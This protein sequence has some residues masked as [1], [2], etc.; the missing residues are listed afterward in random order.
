[1]QGTFNVCLG[2]PIGCM[3]FVLPKKFITIFGRPK[4]ANGG[5]VNIVGTRENW[6]MSPLNPS[7]PKLKRKKCKVR[8]V[9]AWA[10][11]L[12]AWNFS[13]QKSLSLFLAWP[14]P[15]TSPTFFLIDWPRQK[16]IETMKVHKHWKFYGQ[17][18]C[19]P[20]WP[21]DICEKG[22]TLS[23]TYGIKAR[24]DWEHPRG[25]HWEPVGT[26]GKF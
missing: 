5:M 18:K 23:K 25:T 22:R 4:W 13:S 24:C 11:P 9:C 8:L 6:K 19:L 16:K 20:L 21:T 10:F 15:L 17:M 2:L 14:L 12:V 26:K 3:K 1:M 7:P